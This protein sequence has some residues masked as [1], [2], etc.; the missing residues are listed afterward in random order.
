M[1]FQ[2]LMTGVIIGMAMAYPNPFF[3]GMA[4]AAV[5]F[6]IFLLSRSDR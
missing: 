1:Y 6:D 3:I 4:I 2:A 5:L